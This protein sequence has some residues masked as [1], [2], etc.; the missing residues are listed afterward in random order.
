MDQVGPLLYNKVVVR[1]L[2]YSSFYSHVMLKKRT[3]L[4]ERMSKMEQWEVCDT[5]HHL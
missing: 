3:A 1:T 4:H 5:F 2:I